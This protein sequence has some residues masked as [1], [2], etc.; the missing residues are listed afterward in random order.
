[1]AKWKEIWNK[2]QNQL[3]DVDWQDKKAV[4]SALKRMD[5]FDIYHVVF[6]RQKGNY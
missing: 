3:A 2:R 5:G 1:M 6:T 4:L